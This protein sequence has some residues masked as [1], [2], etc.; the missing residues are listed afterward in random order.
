MKILALYKDIARMSLRVCVKKRIS[1]V[2]NRTVLLHF[3]KFLRDV[4]CLVCSMYAF[5]I[6]KP[7]F[8][9]NKLRN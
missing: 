8:I 6:Y 5:S 9:E 2:T 1:F 4:L 3:I 7:I